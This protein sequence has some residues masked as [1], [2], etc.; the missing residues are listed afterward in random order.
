LDKPICGC[1]PG[2]RLG[3]A[4]ELKFDSYLMRRLLIGWTMLWNAPEIFK[5][6]VQSWR[7]PYW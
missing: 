4:I 3:E 2:S 5:S 1:A 6:A 7:K